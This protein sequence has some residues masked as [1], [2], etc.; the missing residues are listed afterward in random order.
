METLEK[1]TNEYVY[2][3]RKLQ[4]KITK[5]VVKIKQWCGIMDYRIVGNI[6][7]YKKL[8][9]PVGNLSKNQM[10]KINAFSNDLEKKMSMRKA[11]SLL[12]RIFKTLAPNEKVQIRK[13]E[14]EEEIQKS[15]KKWLKL[16]NESEK[17]LLVYKT[18][19]GEYY[20][21]RV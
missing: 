10:K 18:E 8:N 14:K 21:N 2:T 9:I 4:E 15:R 6:D 17:A 3:Q 20:K 16:R 13:S 19:K 7:S 5:S 11:S 12:H 1:T